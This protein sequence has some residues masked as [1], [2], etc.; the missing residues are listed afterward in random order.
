MVDRMRHRCLTS[1]TVIAMTTAASR[2]ETS[3]AILAM[4]T[5]VLCRA[6][7]RHDGRDRGG[8][9]CRAG[10]RLSATSRRATPSWR[11]SRP[12][13]SRCSPRG[14]MTRAGTTRRSR[15]RSC[16]SLRTFL[17][18]SDAHR[19]ADPPAGR[20][21][22][23]GRRPPRWSGRSGRRP[24][25]SSSAG[26]TTARSDAASIRD[27]LSRSLAGLALA[28]VDAGLPGTLGIDAGQRRGRVPVPQR[29]RP[30]V[31][32]EAQVEVEAR[33]RPSSIARC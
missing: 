32:V 26:S 2:A 5:R 10:D 17:E 18:V 31:E 14:S 13:R 12:M 9:R 20:A 6:A 16:G 15:R 11:R 33:R 27:L 19:A 8:L 24:V 23:I 21:G 22:R 1:A 7:R 28:A 29:R 3:S 30:P 4:A 25:R